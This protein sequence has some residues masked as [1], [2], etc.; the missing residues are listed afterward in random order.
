M[1]PVSCPPWPGSITILPIFSP[2]A[3]ISDRSPFAVGEASRPSGKESAFLFLLLAGVLEDSAGEA[4]GAGLI[5]GGSSLATVTS[6]DSSA[7]SASTIVL[8]GPA[9]L[10]TRVSGTRL[11]P[12]AGSFA[13]APPAS[14]DEAPSPASELGEFVD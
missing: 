10:V 8:F 2:R 11:L 3:R 14:P 12:V 1:V 7:L 13:C 6:L 9:P 5:S 4:L